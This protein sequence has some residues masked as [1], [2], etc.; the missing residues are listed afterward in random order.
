MRA[1]PDRPAQPDFI[2]RGRLLGLHQQS[3]QAQCL[4][5]GEAGAFLQQLLLQLSG[6]S[7]V[8]GGHENDSP[9]RASLIWNWL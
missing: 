1:G 6:R 9:D 7:P 2:E 8:R 5:E 4:R 3:Q